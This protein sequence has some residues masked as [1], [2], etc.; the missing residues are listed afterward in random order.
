MVLKLYTEATET[1]NIWGVWLRAAGA[2]SSPHTGLRMTRACSSSPTNSVCEGQRTACRNGFPLHHVD[3]G[4][5]LLSARAFIHGAISPAQI[6]GVKTWKLKHLYVSVDP[7]TEVRTPQSLISLQEQW[8]H[9]HR[10]PHPALILRIQKRPSG[11]HA[12]VLHQRSNLP[13]YTF[14]TFFY[15]L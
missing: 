1:Q 5:E 9:R 4:T 13:S 12:K 14:K 10:L 11:L 2:R 7:H 6:S 3:S 15:I 8:G